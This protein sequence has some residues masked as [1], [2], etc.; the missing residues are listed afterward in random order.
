MIPPTVKDLWTRFWM[1]YAGL[2]FFGRMAT[3]LATW[4]APPYYGRCYLTRLNLK[5][6]ISP[7]VTIHH[8][9]LRLGNHVFIG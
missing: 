3:R 4:F 1:H 7:I 2:S 5:G 6:N 8:D 9:K